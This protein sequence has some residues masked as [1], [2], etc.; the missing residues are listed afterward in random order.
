[1]SEDS[2]QRL[3]QQIDA[4][5]DQL[6]ELLGKRAGL[7]QQVG[8][9]K[10]QTNAPVFRPEREAAIVDRMIAANTSALPAETIAAVWPRREVSTAHCCQWKIPQ[11]ERSAERWI[12][13][14]VRH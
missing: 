2:L 9:L 4:V 8:H 13:C 14:C 3:R 6:L 12:S 5:D 11:R 10:E 1:M 7:V